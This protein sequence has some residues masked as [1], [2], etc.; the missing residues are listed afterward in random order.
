MHLKHDLKLQKAK[1]TELQGEMDKPIV[2]G[3]DFH[4]SLS[5]IE[6]RDTKIGEDIECLDNMITTLDTNRHSTR[7]ETF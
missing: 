1:L 6:Q 5:G 2:I 4:S 7:I 3:G